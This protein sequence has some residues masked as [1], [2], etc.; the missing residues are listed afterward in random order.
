[1]AATLQGRVVLV[2]GGGTGIGRAASLAFAREGATVIVSDLNANTGKETAELVR[3]AGGSA[4]FIRADVAI[5]TDVAALID[6]TIA[7]HGRL[8][9]AFNNAGIAG[10]IGS[11]THEYPDD[12]WDRVIAV[13]LKGIWQ[14]MRA[15]IPHM[16]AQGGGAIVNNA[17]IWGLVGAPGAAAYGASKHG[18]A[19]LTRAAAL[20]YAAKGIRINA[21]NPGT[22]RTPI[23]DPFVAAMPDFVPVM[24]AKHPIGHVGQPEE[25]AAV[26]VWLCSDAASYMTGEA[27]VMDG[28]ATA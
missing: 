22:I 7:A 28:G 25:V 18:V 9:C 8:D 21:V 12:G 20:E 6:A 19:G 5:A 1:M 17:S 3:A 24:T 16:L 2:T 14:C 11:L 13:N 4:A 10:P 23:L 27:L 15:E 26:V